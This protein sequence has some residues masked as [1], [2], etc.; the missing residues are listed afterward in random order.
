M[1]PKTNRSIIEDLLPLYQE[2]LLSD[3]TARWLEE[4]IRS[5]EAY[6]HLYELS[7]KP[8]PAPEQTA[9]ANDYEKMMRKISRKLSVYQLIMMAISFFMAISTSMM[10]DSFGFILW[11]AV[12]GLVTFLFYRDIK[13]V[14]L[15]TFVPIFLWLFG[16]MIYE[17]MHGHVTD[18]GLFTYVLLSFLGALLGAALHTVFALIGAAIGWL[19]GRKKPLTVILAVVLSM[20]IAVV[21]DAFNGNPV[22]EW[23][24]KQ[25]LRTYLEETYPER[26]LRIQDGFYNFKFSSYEFDV[27]EIGKAMKNGMTMAYRFEVRGWMREV[28]SDGIRVELRDEALIERL[29][30][31]AALEIEQT[32]AQEID[33]MKAVEVYLEVLKV[34]L[35]EDTVWRKDLPIQDGIQI[36]ITLDATNASREDVLRAAQG[37]QEQLNESRYEYS[38][39]NINANDFGYT[40]SK[41]LG[42]LQYAVSFDQESELSIKDIKVFNE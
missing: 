11:Y 33:S 34:E 17:R 29:S 24:A 4:Q 42:P 12:L 32:L 1:D 5:N 9:S 16:D 23:L 21:Y 41:E 36:Q 10:G 20:G 35:P 13:V 6:Q 14:L 26:E 27:M 40:D 31:Q 8:L 37:I 2:D 38:Y 19:A 3:E 39:V 7:R 15:V 28:V 22:G 25:E 18:T 30:E